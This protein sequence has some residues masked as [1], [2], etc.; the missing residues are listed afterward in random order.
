MQQTS[1]MKQGYQ[2]EPTNEVEVAHQF[3][4]SISCIQ[5]KQLQPCQALMAASSW[6]G[7]VAVYIVQHQQNQS[8]PPV[9]NPFQQTQV[10]GSVLGICWEESA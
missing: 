2:I 5:F 6:D 4:D 3:T 1:S 7:K 10:T 9:V 8:V